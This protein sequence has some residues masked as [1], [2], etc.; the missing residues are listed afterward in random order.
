[1][2]LELYHSRCSLR[3]PRNTHCCK[4]ISR[5]WHAHTR[6][7]RWRWPL[8][9][10]RLLRRLLGHLLSLLLL[11]LLLL[12]HL[13]LLEKLLPALKFCLAHLLPLQLLLQLLRGGHAL[14][15]STT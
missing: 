6:I 5:Y 8:D 9:H 15:C 1:M 14:A 3:W 13:P 2:L 4:L 7:L 10:V 12:K 11:L